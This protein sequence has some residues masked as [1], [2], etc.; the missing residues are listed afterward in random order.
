[1]ANFVAAR[2]PIKGLSHEVDVLIAIGHAHREAR[3]RVWAAQTRA[4]IEQAE[5]AIARGLADENA[6]PALENK[7]PALPTPQSPFA[8]NGKGR[9]FDAE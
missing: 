1:M 9:I 6:T 8:L 4:Q 2:T 7:M 5:V 3:A